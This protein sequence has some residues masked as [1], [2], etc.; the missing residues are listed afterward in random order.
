L[1]LRLEPCR[2]VSGWYG[3]IDYDALAESIAEADA[4]ERVKVVCLEMGSTG[5][6]CNGAQE[7]AERIAAIGKP[8][9]VYTPGLLCSAAYFVA[10]SAD[11]IVAAPSSMVGNIGAYL[12]FYDSSKLFGDVGIKVQVISSGE[13]KATGVDGTQLTEAQVA[14]LQA[15]V[16]GEFNAFFSHV[17]SYRDGLDIS[18]ADGRPV[19]G[20]DAVA[21]GL[22]DGIANTLEDAIE[23]WAGMYA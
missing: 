19:F 4:D 9:V 18:L 2:G 17:T 10:A 14:D 16:N 20:R 8:L 15:G 1:K 23:A 21:V 6:C 11:A 3:C 22:T 12:V 5:G 13:L 7:C